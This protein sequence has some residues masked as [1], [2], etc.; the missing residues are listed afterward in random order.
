MPEIMAFA[1]GSMIG[2]FLNVCI[3][4]MPKDESIAFPASHCM[5]C[6]KPIAWFDNI[7]V[8]SFLLLGAKCRHCRVKIS[9]QYPLIEIV[10][11]ILFVIFYRSFGLTPKGFLYLYLSLV[12]LTQGVIDL[13]YKIIP[14]ELSLPPIASFLSTHS[15]TVPTRYRNPPPT[16]TPTRDFKNPAQCVDCAWI[17]GKNA[18]AANPTTMAG[19]ESSSGMIL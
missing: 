10:T 12:L 17:S 16:R 5:S 4:R 19:S 2:S 13:R 7:P 14:D 1:L 6:K 15:A 9:W 18:D 8:V 3:L 11:G